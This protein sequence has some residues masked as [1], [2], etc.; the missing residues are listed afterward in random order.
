VC[1]RADPRKLAPPVIAGPSGVVRIPAP[2][3]PHNRHGI[4]AF[5][6]LLPGLRRLAGR[7]F[8]LLVLLEEAGVGDAT[9][10]DALELR[11]L[12]IRE[13]LDGAHSSQPTERR[14]SSHEESPCEPILCSVCWRSSRC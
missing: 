5:R 12:L 11:E 8:D 2:R 3:R 10:R 1:W 13:G 9:C 6:R 4:G 7:H 14:A